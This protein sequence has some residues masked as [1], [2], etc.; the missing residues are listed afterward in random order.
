MEKIRKIFESLKLKW[1]KETSLTILL[2]GIIA[3][4]FVLINLWLESL[5]LTDIDLTEEKLYSLTET[6]KE[7]LA[8]IPAEDKIEI[9]LF[10]FIENSSV[11]DLAKQYAK[12]NK[13]ISIEIT[14][15]ADR[16]DLAS[17]YEI[18]DGNYSILIVSGEKYK[19][20]DSY[21]LYTYD[22]NTGNSIDMTEQK[23]TNG[24]IAISSIGKQTQI[25]IL[26]G[27]G[28]FSIQS[29][30]HTLNTYLQTE[31]YELKELDLL[32]QEEVPEDCETLIIS[33]PKKDITALEAEKI[34]TYI[35]KGGDI[36][37]MNDVLS[38]E[39]ET[40]NIQSILD[41]YGVNIHQNGI[42]IEQD[43]SKM[44]MQSPDII[45]PTINYSILTED[46][47]SQGMV[48][49]F[50]TSKLSFANDEKL[51]DLGITKTELLTTSQKAIYRTDLSIPNITPEEG[52]EVGAHVVGALLEKS[53]GEN[54]TSKLVIY[55]NNYFATDKSVVV[56]YQ[57]VP[58]IY[59]YNNLD[60]VLNSVA[61]LSEVEDQITIR[62]SIETTNY[63]ATETQD[64]IVRVIIFGVP[65]L[66]ILLRN[67][68]MGIKKK[69]EII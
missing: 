38:Q 69:K 19:V 68:S 53:I 65:I 21:D 33:S 44:V 11:A 14:T 66:I 36:L 28:E 41:I 39:G 48:A 60:L 32:V 31:N 47:A 63:T 57:E 40:P 13:N 6:S 20:F 43:T 18:Q 52:D 12:V 15:I 29:E 1:L 5:D 37:W 25:Y 35:N 58:A 4:A 56:G 2:I 64:I 61:Y 7:Q 8:K 3:L 24:I 55:A 26:T 27:H 10:G 16:I 17:K 45:L 42:I 22:Y 49:F 59:F 50:D 51:E 34:K 9:Y 30:L 62:K 46:L 23:L 67:S 54:N